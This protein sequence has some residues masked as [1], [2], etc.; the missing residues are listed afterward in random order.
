M[1][2]AEQA[3]LAYADT[4]GP[5]QLRRL[6]RRILEVAAPETCEEAEG[7]ALEREERRAAAVTSL[8]FRRLGDGT[9]RISGRLADSVADRLRTYLDAF[10]SPRHRG[11]G[12]GDRV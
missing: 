3:L 6:G 1:A 2:R 10:T 12:E 5:R 9:T 8:T 4:Y 7:K 11:V